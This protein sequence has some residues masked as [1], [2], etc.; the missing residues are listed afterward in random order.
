MSIEIQRMAFVVH[1]F[2]WFSSQFVTTATLYRLN[3]DDTCQQYFSQ[4]PNLFDVL[5]LPTHVLK[6]EKEKII[7]REIRNRIGDE[8]RKKK[9]KN[10]KKKI[11]KNRSTRIAV[12]F[13]DFVLVFVAALLLFCSHFADCV[14]PDCHQIA[15]IN[16]TI[17]A[18][19]RINLLFCESLTTKVVLCVNVS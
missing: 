2:E 18:S 9:K 6:I 13:L 10:T 16:S 7:I 15:R 11:K 4:P 1:H 14:G 12:N 5:A 17:L 8:F 19:E 3:K